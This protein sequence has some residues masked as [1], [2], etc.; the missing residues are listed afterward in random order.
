M[1][2]VN[3]C[4]RMTPGHGTYAVPD[5]SEDYRANI[6]LIDVAMPG[7]GGLLKA[8]G[9]WLQEPAKTAN[10][11]AQAL[12]EMARTAGQQYKPLLGWATTNELLAVLDDSDAQRTAASGLVDLAQ[13]RFDTPWDAVTVDAA[14]IPGHTD[15]LD[16]YERFL[17]LLSYTVRSAGLSF[18]VSL[19]AVAPR[20]ELVSLDLGVIAQIADT[21]YW[22]IYSWSEMPYPISPYW[23]AV[24]SLD[25][26]LA[27]GI[28]PRRVQ[29]GIVNCCRHVPVTGERYAP[30]CGYDQALEIVHGHNARIEWMERNETGL[31]R[32]K[33]AD[34][35]EGHI[36]LHDGDTVKPRLALAD[37]HGLGGMML[38]C[39]GMGDVSAWQAIA[40]WKRPDGCRG[41][42]TAQ[43]LR[44]CDGVFS[45]Y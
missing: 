5:S 6:G 29:L 22:C 44:G 41:R 37:E 10:E 33:W 19:K 28:S 13:G 31:I 34:L 20:H 9:S 4:L 17:R 35:G 32:E 11:F 8:N 14:D 39:P 15:Y 18:G 30:L 7:N 12:P 2:T 45:P 36:W 3:A 25:N 24:E 21:V 43:K 26:A 1:K 16:K 40:E 27:H 23:W 42:M 38:F